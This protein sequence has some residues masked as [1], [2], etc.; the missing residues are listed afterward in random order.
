MS[1]SSDFLYVHGY[2]TRIE[3]RNGNELNRTDLVS[4]DKLTN[5]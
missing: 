2:K 4:I 1:I 5:G 3:R